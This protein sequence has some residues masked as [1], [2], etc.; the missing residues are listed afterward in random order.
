[1]SINKG[2]EDLTKFYS[3]FTEIFKESD[4]VHAC[5][6]VDTTYQREERTHHPRGALV[7]DTEDID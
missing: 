6:A 7:T 4:R 1:M 3:M 5:P 2:Q